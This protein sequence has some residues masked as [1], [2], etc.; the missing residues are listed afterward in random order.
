MRLMFSDA[1]HHLLISSLDDFYCAVPD[2]IHTL[3]RT[4]LA[5]TF[6]QGGVRVKPKTFFGDG[7]MII[8]WNI[9]FTLRFAKICDFFGFGVKICSSCIFL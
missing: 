3:Y 1:K 9:T 8:F 5:S 2:N 7:S 4:S 6:Q